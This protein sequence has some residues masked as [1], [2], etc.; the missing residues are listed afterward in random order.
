L[1]L[2]TLSR[3][4]SAMTSANADKAGVAAPPPLVYLVAIVIG[5]VLERV[6]RWRLSAARWTSTLGALLIA[7]AI[8]L[9]VWA[10]REFSRARTS[11]KP[12]EPTTAIVA[13]GPFAFTRNPIYM[14]FTLVQLGV[15][16]LAQSGW[17]LVLLVPAL[18]FIQLG[19][20]A[21]EERYLESKFGDEYLRYRRTVRR[22]L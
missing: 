4:I 5:A 8:V 19:V 6:W 20:I 3:T 1:F 15:A 14:S 13:S 2:G 12:H 17:I 10:V 7:V 21:R 9:F 22:W 16:L 11:P 18:L